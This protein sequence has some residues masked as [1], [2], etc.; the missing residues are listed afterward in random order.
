MINLIR[1]ILIVQKWQ[2]YIYIPFILFFIIS[3]VPPLL[4]FL[5][6]S[7]FI[8]YNAFTY[9]EQAET[10]MLLN[11]LPYTRR[12]IIASRYIGAI[13]YMIL[14][15]VITSGFLYLFQKPFTVSDILM[16]A[17]LFLIFAALTFPV[18]VLVKQG[19]ITLFLL[20]G[21]LL[22]VWLIRPVVSFMTEKFPN[23]TG[24]VTSL[25]NTTLYA[26]SSVL[27]V[28]LYSISWG[29]STMMYERKVL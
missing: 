11:S 13:I 23:L 16:G 7:T 22:S 17:G 21:F 26:A 1:R 9:D 18:Y 20:V 14:S 3:N 29:I 24:L 6:A 19:N 12:E 28:F 27:V 2:L 25:S 5:V 8:P 15:I 10:D 4:T